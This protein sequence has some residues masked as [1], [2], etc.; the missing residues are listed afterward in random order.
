MMSLAMA[1]PPTRTPVLARAAMIG[2][3]AEVVFP[4]TIPPFF[5]SGSLLAPMPSNEEFDRRWAGLQAHN[6]WLA[7][8]C[9]D[10]PGRRAGIER[11][12]RGERLLELPRNPPDRRCLLLLDLVLEDVES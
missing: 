11:P 4:N 12:Q 2:I 10:T 5:P 8:F 3:A 7:D 9:A 6:R 1:T